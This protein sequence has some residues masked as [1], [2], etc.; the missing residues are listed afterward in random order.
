MADDKTLAALAQVTQALS[1]G[2]SRHALLEEIAWPPSI[3][4]EFFAKKEGSLPKP[5][6]AE[7]DRASNAA[8]VKAIEEARAK[9]DGEGPVHAWLDGVL[10][11]ARDKERLLGALGTRDFGV[12]SGEIYGGAR[13]SVFGMK[14]VD[15]A[16]HLLSRLAIHGA[17]TVKDTADQP[18]TSH[19]L[20]VWMKDRIE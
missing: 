2:K 3:E 19:E 6:V 4:A 7:I 14:N 11:S 18:M 12:I 1:V 9:L 10:A 8:A 17:D 13:T 20:V 15:L 5:P 16:E